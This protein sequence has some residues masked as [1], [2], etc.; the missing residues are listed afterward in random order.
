MISAMFLAARKLGGD[1]IFW[2]CANR[3]YTPRILFYCVLAHESLRGED[4][5]AGHRIDGYL[6]VQDTQ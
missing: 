1:H 6:K 4:S 2:T 3:L 5:F